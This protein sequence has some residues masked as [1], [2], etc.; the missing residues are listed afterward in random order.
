MK[1]LFLLTIIP[2]LMIFVINGSQAKELVINSEDQLSFA[3]KYMDRGEFEKAIV[4]LERYMFFFP[5]DEDIPFA[6]YLTGKCYIGLKKY[7]DARKILEK[8]YTKDTAGTYADKAL[9]LI[10]EAFYKE[11]MYEEAEICFTG[12]VREHPLSDLKDDAAYRQGWSQLS[13]DKWDA[14]ADTFKS[15]DKDSPLYTPSLNIYEELKTAPDYEQKNPLTA[16]ILAG[17]IPGLGHA[18]S[19]RYRDGLTAFVVNGLFIWAAAEAFE[20]DNE[21]LGGILSFLEAGWYAGNIYSAVN[22]AHKY[23][24]K[25]KNDFLLRLNENAG[26]NLSLYG[27]QNFGL[28]FNINL[29]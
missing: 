3:Q 5:H 14:A 27:N 26:F 23:N 24:R 25:A 10:G 2:L 21:A 22:C 8:L 11:G 13:G 28:S 17:V 7:T 9:F 12:L 29:N 20:D 18:Y 15:M 1:K 4:E 6:Q 16:G 19:N